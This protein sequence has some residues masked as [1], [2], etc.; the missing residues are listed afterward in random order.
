[1]SVLTNIK[2]NSINREF[3][4]RPYRSEDTYQEQLDGSPG[5]NIASAEE[6]RITLEGWRHK[7]DPALLDGQ[8]IFPK[9]ITADEIK[10]ETITIGE[11]DGD[12]DDITDGSTYEKVRAVVI[13]SGTIKI[14]RLN[15][16]T[17]ERLEITASGVEG[18]ANNVK[19][20]ELASGIAY[21]G[22]QSNEHIKLSSTGLEIKD[23]STVL[24]TYGST[25][26]I[27]EVGASK[28]NVHI[29]SGELQMRV[30]TTSSITL[31]T[32]GNIGMV[33]GMTISG[34][35]GW[36]K[37]YDTQGTPQLRVHIGYIA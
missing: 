36:I 1:M 33:G 18:Y 2:D 14:L 31:D 32:S 28:S 17:T 13:D 8:S 19:N 4:S 37:V 25:V 21:L 24:A 7:S 16:D 26:T 10:V 27:G 34:T 12:L 3:A 6:T 9:S 15:A 5:P 30:N 23:S 11:I 35:G 20:F 22:D 29:T